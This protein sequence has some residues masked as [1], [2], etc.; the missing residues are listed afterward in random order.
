MKKYEYKFVKAEVKLGFAQNKKIEET[1]RE[2]NA[3]GNE[4]WKFCKEGNGVMIFM[5][6]VRA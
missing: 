5:R 1:E 2:W 6:E 3:L 4:G